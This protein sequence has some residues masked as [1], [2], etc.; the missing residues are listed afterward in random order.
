MPLELLLILVV[1]GIAAVTLVLHLL[2]LSDVP[3]LDA[4]QAKAAWDR[5]YPA[6]P[7][8]H[9]TPTPNARAALIRTQNGQ[10]GLVWRFGADTVAHPLSQYRITETPTGLTVRFRD[11]AT[12][13]VHVPLPAQVRAAWKQ[14]LEPAG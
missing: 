7:A 1:G 2:G 13:S 3:A 12:P 14:E 11:Y 9:C 6:D 10:R 5:E 8:I 4:A